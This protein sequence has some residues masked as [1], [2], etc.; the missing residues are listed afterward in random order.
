MSQLPIPLA[1]ITVLEWISIVIMILVMIGIFALMIYMMFTKLVRNPTYRV[2]LCVM[3][4]LYIIDQFFVGKYIQYYSQSSLLL[5]IH[6]SLAVILFGA[7]GISASNALALYQLLLP[8]IT[9][10]KLKIIRVIIMIGLVWNLGIIFVGPTL[11]VKPV[12]FLLL[13]NGSFFCYLMFVVIYDEVQNIYLV[14]QVHNSLNTKS[15]RDVAKH[16]KK[17]VVLNASM[18]TLD[19]IALVTMFL[20]FWIR[21][22]ELSMQRVLFNFSTALQGIHG[23]ILVALFN[24]LIEMKFSDRIQQ[25]KNEKLLASPSLKKATVNSGSKL[26]PETNVNKD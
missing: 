2:C 19:M 10:K 26:N 21:S 9:N 5:M 6:F 12:W 8:S 11:S 15:Q 3:F 24:G 18:I 13:S 25:I 7:I 17:L 20:A 4:A 16:F 23:F 14:I 22:D 1:Q